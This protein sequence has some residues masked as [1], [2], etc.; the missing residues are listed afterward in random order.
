MGLL[1][2]QGPPATSPEDR[3]TG[4]STPRVSAPCQRAGHCSLSS[5]PIDL[6][7]T[8]SLTAC[9]S[10]LPAPKTTFERNEKRPFADSAVL[11]QC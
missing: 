8:N 6:E 7:T 11:I 1:G 10:A 9:H 2:L 5:V 3:R 4:P